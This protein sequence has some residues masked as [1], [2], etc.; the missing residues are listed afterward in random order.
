MA[1]CLRWCCFA[2]CTASGDGFEGIDGDV[3][4][5]PSGQRG[6]VIRFELPAE[7]DRGHAAFL[8]DRKV[9]EDASGRLNAFVGL[10]HQAFVVGDRA[11]EKGP[12]TTRRRS[13]S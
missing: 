11:G 9:M 5:S 1:G 6:F 12:S 3:S 7:A 2:G 10:D 13:A 8:R 4:A